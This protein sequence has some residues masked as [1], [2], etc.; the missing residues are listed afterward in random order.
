MNRLSYKKVFSAYEKSLGHNMSQFSY[1]VY[2][3]T[4]LWFKKWY[5]LKEH[6]KYCFE[7][8]DFIRENS[9]DIPEGID[10][11][12]LEKV[13]AI[14]DLKYL[15]F[16]DYLPK[17]DIELFKNKLQDFV[18]KNDIPMYSAYI[19]KEDSERINDMARYLDGPSFSRLND[20]KMAKSEFLKEYAP[21]L[22]VSIHNLS[23]SFLLVKYRFYISEKFNHE[24][25]AL[26]TRKF[27]PFTDVS[28]RFD[29]PWYKPWRFGRAHFTGDNARYKEI[30]LK[31][32]E[33]KWKIFEE[34]DN[35]FKLYF[36]L[37]QCFPPTFATYR[38]NIPISIEMTQTDFWKSISEDYFPDYSKKYNLCIAWGAKLGKY[39]GLRISAYCG[40]KIDTNDNSPDI[41][42]YYISNSYGVYIVASTMRRVAKRN[43]E[44]WNKEVSK[45]IRKSK[46]STL[47]KVRNKVALELYYV[48]RFLNEFSGKTLDISDVDSFSNSVMKTGTMT[49]KSFKGLVTLV[50]ETK[51]QIDLLLMFLN[52][53]I[54][55]RISQSNRKLE[56]I[57][58]I[59]T[60]ISLL[61]AILALTDFKINF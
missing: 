13:D 5:P 8:D 47:L 23:T 12:T 14:I 49:S 2:K 57:M 25:N 9:S 7:F 61:V 11:K 40:G 21:Q 42:E 16:F 17:E 6:E 24:L 33:L 60:I 53:S 48:Y 31:I 15:D 36:S 59:I 20:I 1:R 10:K 4:R 19:T 35:T 58:A 43:M 46:S 28:R 3:K 55:Y 29:I 26:Y 34:I 45:A 38:T 54:E 39:E 41:G 22:T 44:V 56:I 52:N 27:D 30:Y 37:N 32:S 18:K 51:K 50:N